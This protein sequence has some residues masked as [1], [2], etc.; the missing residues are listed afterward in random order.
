MPRLINT[1]CDNC[2]FET[3]LQ[4][5]ER[6]DLAIVKSVAGDLGLLGKPVADIPAEEQEPAMPSKE[7]PEE[8][9]DEIDKMLDGLEQKA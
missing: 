5:K 6:V 8:D 9:F 7:E 1:I 3:Y 2:L 4:K